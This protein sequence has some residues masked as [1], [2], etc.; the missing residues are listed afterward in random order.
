M[1]SKLEFDV[2]EFDGGGYHFLMFFPCGVSLML[3]LI[4]CTFSSMYFPTGDSGGGKYFSVFLEQPNDVT[5]VVKVES[6][7]GD[8]HTLVRIVALLLLVS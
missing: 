5:F 6:E 1:I 7:C 8:E 2:R 4:S 3:F